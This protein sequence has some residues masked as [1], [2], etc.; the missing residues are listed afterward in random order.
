[1]SVL[2]APLPSPR[3][4]SVMERYD[5]ERTA[6]FGKLT[7]AIE[8]VADK[9]T[10]GQYKAIYDAAMVIYQ[11][12]T[13]PPGVRAMVL[14]AESLNQ[15]A[16]AAATA[17]AAQPVVQQALHQLHDREQRERV[18]AYEREAVN[19]MR[20]ARS[21][22]PIEAEWGA[23]WIDQVDEGYG[24]PHI[25]RRPT[26]RDVLAY[27]RMGALVRPAQ[28]ASPPPS[29]GDAL[30]DYM[31]YIR[32]NER[33]PRLSHTLNNDEVPPDDEDVDPVTPLHTYEE[34]FP[35]IHPGRGSE[36]AP[37]D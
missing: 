9:I 33:P 35:E 31:R 13:P 10:D 28:G 19:A 27:H 22:D 18:R 15:V 37:V 6:A 32:R 11:R 4:M 7:E 21:H 24:G 30:R 29:S 14:D 1:M 12:S 5:K 8:A 26:A 3:R 17:M 20:A 25:V 16:S 36:M 2:E 34:D 23:M